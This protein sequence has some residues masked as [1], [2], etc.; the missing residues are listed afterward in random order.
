MHF[1]RVEASSQCRAEGGSA[2]VDWTSWAKAD[3]G[4]KLATLLCYYV[5]EVLKLVADCPN[6]L[7]R[8]GVGSTDTFSTHREDNLGPQSIA[9]DLVGLRSDTSIDKKVS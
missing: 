4:S 8:S 2:V 3:N 9:R 5:V 6:P 7:R 1:K